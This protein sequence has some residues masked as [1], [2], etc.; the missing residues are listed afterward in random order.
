MSLSGCAAGHKLVGGALAGHA[1]SCVAYALDPIN[2]RPHTHPPPS[3]RVQMTRA[4]FRIVR[5][6]RVVMRRSHAVFAE[7]QWSSDSSMPVLLTSTTDATCGIGDKISTLESECD[8]VARRR[9]SSP[10]VGRTS[11]CLPVGGDRFECLRFLE[12]MLRAESHRENGD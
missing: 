5:P 3:R 1:R 12:L 9:S 10:A 11:H 4:R 6:V 8:R 7:S 2:S